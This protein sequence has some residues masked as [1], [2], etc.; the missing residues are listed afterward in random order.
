[1]TMPFRGRRPSWWLSMWANLFCWW[2]LE[3][4]PYCYDIHLWPWALVTTR[5]WGEQ[6]TLISMTDE[7]G[8]YT[9]WLDSYRRHCKMS[10]LL[11]TT[12]CGGSISSSF[13]PD[14]HSLNLLAKGFRDSRNR[15]V[16]GFDE[17]LGLVLQYDYYSSALKP[18]PFGPLARFY[19]LR[20]GQVVLDSTP[21]KGR[22]TLSSQLVT[23]K[24]A[25]ALAT[26]QKLLQ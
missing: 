18:R 4:V 25:G 12:Q 20:T 15:R 17:R 26:S 13:T 7:P 23:L 10:T 8:M 22:A 1:M 3:V 6:S 2:N 11:P 5:K 16:P 14:D 9:I 19:L 21:M 24:D